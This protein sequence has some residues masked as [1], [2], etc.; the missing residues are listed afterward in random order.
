MEYSQKMGLGV[1]G[2]VVSPG[3]NL[4]VF[5]GI[6]SD[7]R[8]LMERFGI[9]D[10]NGETLIFADIDSAVGA[11]MASRGD[12]I[13]VAPG[14]TST[15]S[16]ATALALD[17]AGITIKGLGE[18]TKRPTLTFDT[19]N[20]ATIAVSVADVVIE[21]VVFSANYAD[22]A[23]LFT[24]TT[25]KNFTLRNCGF[26]ATASAMNF[27]TLVTTNATANAS[28]GLTIDNCSWV[29]PDT[30]TSTM[31][32]VVGDLDGLTVKDSYLNLG[33]NTNDLPAIAIVATGKDLTNVM[34][35]SN[36]VIR[37]NDANAL[38]ITADTTTANTGIVKNNNVRHLDT[39]GELLVTTAT[40]I[41]FF[42]NNATAA[43]DKSGFIIPAIDA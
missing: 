17:V 27:L 5:S 38:L 42:R 11:C 21:N 28:D 39:A 8:D 37:L 29:E 9:N 40:N 31:L 18:G 16:S 35:D 4:L 23:S 36:D 22:I 1:G 30:A 41:G 25:A 6:A 19:A 2:G 7:A 43:V 3:K 14:H 33:V 15:I 34:I 26:V 32:T 20:T 24:L 13:Y 10:Y 12:T